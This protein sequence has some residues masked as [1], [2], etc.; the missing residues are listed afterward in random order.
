MGDVPES[1]TR[2]GAWLRVQQA[3][4]LLGVSASTMRRWADAGKV[5]SHRSPGGQ[6]VFAR[7]DLIAVL[8][9][10]SHPPGGES[11]ASRREHDRRMALLLEATRAVTSTLVLEDVLTLV[12]RTTAEAMGTFAADIFDYSAADNAMVAS[13]YWALDI[14]PEDDEYLGSRIS[15]DERPGFYPYVDAPRLLE[16]TARLGRLGTRGTRDLRALGREERARGAADVRR[17]TDRSSGMHREA[18]RAPFHG[19]GQGAPRAPGRTCGHGHPQR[20]RL[21]RAGGAGAPA[22]DAARLRP[23]RDLVASRRRGPRRPGAQRVG[24]SGLSP[25]R[26]LRLRLPP[27]TP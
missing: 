22:G 17:R 6:R 20:P 19:R 25:V 12:A 18:S 9:D 1:T 27:A 2:P 4:E 24:G 10:A 7:A 5:A 23:R 14:T 11:S 13:G 8:P 3:A 26:D 15:L 16:T 21:P